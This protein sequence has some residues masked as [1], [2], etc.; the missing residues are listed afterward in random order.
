M[1]VR[2]GGGH[3][4]AQAGERAGATAH[5]DGVEITHRQTRIIK[6][7]NNIGREPFGVRPGIDGDPLGQHGA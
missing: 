1:P 7:G 3:P 2:G 6:S 5:H 4:R